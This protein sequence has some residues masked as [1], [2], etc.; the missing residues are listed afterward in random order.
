MVSAPPKLV[1]FPLRPAD[2]CS[3]G[4]AKFVE[5][6]GGSITGEDSETITS[7]VSSEKGAVPL[8]TI[9]LVV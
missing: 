7:T 5:T 4:S 9:T 6:L 8:S 3:I 1:R 2:V